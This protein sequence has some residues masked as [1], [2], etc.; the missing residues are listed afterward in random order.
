MSKLF[1]ILGCIS[2]FVQ[3][4]VSFGI[5]PDNAPDL[6]VSYMRKD[7]IEEEIVVAIEIHNSPVV[8][9]RVKSNVLSILP[10]HRNI[11]CRLDEGDEYMIRINGWPSEPIEIEVI[12]IQVYYRDLQNRRYVSELKVSKCKDIGKVI[13]TKRTFKK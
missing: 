1:E 7:P 13:S 12:H 5:L 6:R 10:E 4:I 11:N 9:T 8:V 3:K 2:N